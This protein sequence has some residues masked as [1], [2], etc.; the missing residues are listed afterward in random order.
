MARRRQ[1][2]RPGRGLEVESKGGRLR[3][4]R[5]APPERFVRAAGPER[6]EHA[7]RQ[8]STWSQ[9]RHLPRCLFGA[10]ARSCL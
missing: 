1:E 6:S 4:G 5:S 10:A 9:Q 8:R 3:R 2:L 7:K